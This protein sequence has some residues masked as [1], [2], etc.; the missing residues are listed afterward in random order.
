MDRELFAEIQKDCPQFNRSITRGLACEQLKHVEHYIERVMR[1]AERGFPEDVR[2]SHGERV[3]PMEEF[4]V[5]TA[6]RSTKKGSKQ[7]FEFSP[8]DIYMVKYTF[9][10]Q[11]QIIKPVYMYMPFARPG[12]IITITGNK[13]SI[14]PVLADKAISVGENDIFIPLNLDKLTFKRAYHHFITDGERV[15]V[16]V[17]WCDIYHRRNKATRLGNRRVFKSLSTM[18]HY[19]FAKFGLK[20]TFKLYGKADIAYGDSTNITTDNY[21]ASEW[22]ICQ[23]TQMKPSD[24]RNKYHPTHELRIAIKKS[25]YNDFNASLIATFFYVTDRY[26]TKMNAA[27]ID[28]YRLWR[29]VLGYIIFMS[30]E[31][32]GKILNRVDT[33]IESLD[34]YIDGM[35]IEWLSEDNVHVESLYDL[36]AHVIETFSYRIANAGTD[37]ASMYNKKLVVLRYV[38][39]DIITAIFKLMFA[40]RAASKKGLTKME[41]E[42]KMREHLKM[43][44]IN[45]INHLHGEVSSASSSTDVMSFKLTTNLRLQTNITNSAT[46]NK[47]V[48]VGA[49]DL[50]HVSIAEIGQYLNL[51]KAE[52]TGRQ[53]LNHFQQLGPNWSTIQDPA[54]MDVTV[55]TQQH[56]QYVTLEGEEL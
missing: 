31:T 44:L 47:V 21:P 56:F 55:K 20:E 30:D 13:Y 27:F 6:K 28:D 3:G 5:L 10:F 18:G 16:P 25:E 51:P 33:H 29:L 49:A 14:S 45:K 8:S 9:E 32:E 38:L 40:L 24:I 41:V 48:S 17:I 39:F 34:G 50:L 52:P 23:S 11:G 15:S 2:F 37:I 7:I 1:S 36:I 46:S 22:Y 43:Y 54:K 26:P 4:N 12:G 42:K 53:R 19:L 35:A